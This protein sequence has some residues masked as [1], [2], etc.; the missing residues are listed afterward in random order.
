MTSGIYILTFSS[1]HFYIGKSNHIERRWKE[2]ATKFDKGTAA[3]NMQWAYD[4]YGYPKQ[5]IMYEV[6]PDHIDVI[7]PIVINNS[8]GTKI[9]NTTKGECATDMRDEYLGICKSS[10]G[11]ICKVLLEKN[12]RITELEAELEEETTNFEELLEDIKSGTE[13]ELVE[14]KLKGTKAELKV[15]KELLKKQMEEVNRL[16]NRTFFQRLFD[17]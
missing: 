16:K 17:L 5:E 10:L 3:K 14:E 4:N 12:D 15:N 8:W 2:H 13:L 6:H 11:V 7:E 9:L 1:G